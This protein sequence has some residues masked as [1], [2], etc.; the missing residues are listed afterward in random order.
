MNQSLYSFNLKALLPLENYLLI[1]NEK[2]R[3]NKYIHSQNTIQIK[4]LDSEQTTRRK[5]CHC[6]QCG[7]QSQLQFKTMNIPLKKREILKEQE[8][9]TPELIV[10]NSDCIQRLQIFLAKMNTYYKKS[11]FKNLQILI[12]KDNNTINTQLSLN[13]HGFKRAYNK[14]NTLLKMITD[15]QERSKR[16]DSIGL[17]SQSDLQSINSQNYLNIATQSSLQNQ[18]NSIQLKSPVSTF[19]PKRKYQNKHTKLLSTNIRNQNPY[20]IN[21]N[22]QFLI[23]PLKLQTSL[24]SLQ[25]QLPKLNKKAQ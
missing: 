16:K 4:Q 2:T 11:S 3:L 20:I 13:I 17:Y 24:S 7:Q 1:L 12:P 6:G 5:S 19:S 25:N 8:Y 9:F 18:K 21:L 10:T 22:R 14:Q 15:G 23:R